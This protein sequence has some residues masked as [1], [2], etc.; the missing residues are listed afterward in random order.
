MA[1]QD[2]KQILKSACQ[3]FDPFAL[4]P[5]SQALPGQLDGKTGIRCTGASVGPAFVSYSNPISVQ[6]N[7]Q[8][9]SLVA[10]VDGRTACHSA[11]HLKNSPRT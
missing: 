1:V 2:Q 10:R 3:C 5:S 4:D 6:P 9:S 7:F 8:I 11:N